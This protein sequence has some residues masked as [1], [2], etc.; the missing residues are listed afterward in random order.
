MAADRLREDPPRREDNN[1]AVS[2]RGSQPSRILSVH[3]T[4][5]GAS[6]GD[7]VARRNSEA[8]GRDAGLWLSNTYAMSKDFWP[9]A[10][11][12]GAIGEKLN[13]LTKFVAS[14]KLRDAPWGTFPAAT[15]THDPVAT[16]RELKQQSGKDIWLW[17]SLT[18]MQSMFDADVVDEVQLRVCATTRG[19]GS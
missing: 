14:T 12:Q 16:I 18:L 4:G 7:E 5:R 6:S 13:R 3:Q 2:G 10:K 9:T 17:G 8:S 19:K 11:D 15:I 1:Q